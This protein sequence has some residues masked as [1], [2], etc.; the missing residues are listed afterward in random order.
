MAPSL[1][2]WPAEDRRAFLRALVVGAAAFS[3]APL[4]LRGLLRTGHELDRDEA[5]I[6][7]D[8]AVL[9]YYQAVLEATPRLT[10]GPFFPN[11]DMPTDR[12]ND[13]LVVGDAATPALG[14]VVHLQGRVLTKSGEPVKDA[15]VHIWQVDSTG[16]YIHRGSVGHAKRDRNFQGYGAFETGRD[17]AYKFRTLRPVRYPGR[18]PHIHLAVDRKGQSRFSTQVIDASDPQ[19]ARDGVLLSIRDPAKRSLVLREFSPAAGKAEAVVEFDV[20]LD[21]AVLA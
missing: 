16:A 10:E 18:T 20:V 19:T 5:E 17:G 6:L 1:P 11:D 15:T 3:G 8:P 7:A 9:A 21:D 14:P 4:L 12:D 13:L 2:D